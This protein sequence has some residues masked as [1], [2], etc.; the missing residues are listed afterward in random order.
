MPYQPA[1]HLNQPPT[2]LNHAVRPEKDLQQGA[3]PCAAAAAGV[4]GAAAAVHSLERGG[5]ES[6]EYVWGGR[7]QG[8]WGGQASGEGR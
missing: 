4:A 5:G 7:C 3:A 1:T 6:G 2:H 8:E